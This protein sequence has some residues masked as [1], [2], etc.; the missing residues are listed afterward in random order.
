MNYHSSNKKAWEEA[1][2]Y[3]IEGWG[4]DII[5][6]INNESC[7]F[8][9]KSLINE[10]SGYDFKDKSIAQF[11]CNNGR[12]LMSLYKMGAA[13]GVGFDIAENMI[14]F[15]NDA[16]K[17]LNINC[18]FVA[19]DIFDI[20]SRYHEAFDYIFITVG[21]ITW[22][23]DLNTFFSKV[24]AC[25]KSDGYLIM[26]EIH[27]VTG[28]LAFDGEDNYDA[29][30]PNKMVNSYFKDDPWVENNGMAYMS[31]MTKEYKEVFHSYS[32]TLGHII[33]SISDC[34]MRI[35]KLTESESD[36]TG[37][38]NAIEYSGIPM[39]YILIAQKV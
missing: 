18:S 11:C 36:I 30:S 16:A 13:M 24:V 37:S 12:E 39:S 14:S 34:G 25:L 23:K 20:D 31:D 29:T 9:E 10:L 21:A 17:K 5:E 22:F 8:L 7:P 19:T 15:A 32:H 3:R 38:F 4:E 27:P 33:T 6:K 28:M 2:E 1:Y 35:R 26:Q